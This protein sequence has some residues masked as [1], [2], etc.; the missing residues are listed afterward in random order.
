MKT[1]DWL[2]QIA[3]IRKF[4][5]KEVTPPQSQ[6]LT[7]AFATTEA[8]SNLF[9]ELATDAKAATDFINNIVPRQARE[10]INSQESKKVETE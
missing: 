2:D 9:M 1:Q 3:P 4:E 6:Q 10:A 8:Y 7:D 5:F